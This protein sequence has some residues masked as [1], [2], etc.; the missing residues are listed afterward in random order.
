MKPQIRFVRVAAVGPTL[1][2]IDATAGLPE[3]PAIAGACANCEGGWRDPRCDG[4]ELTAA[5]T[6]KSPNRALPM[7]V[8]TDTLKETA[9]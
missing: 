8:E 2:Q 5:T 7:W 1:R 6:A 3:G 9:L 4:N